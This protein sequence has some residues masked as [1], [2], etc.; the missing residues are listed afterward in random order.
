MAGRISYRQKYFENYDVICIA[1]GTNDYEIGTPIG[2]VVDTNVDTFYGA[3]MYIVERI[4]EQNPKAKV[5]FITPFYRGRLLNER[6]INCNFKKNKL[7]YTLRDYADAIKAV[8]DVHRYNVYD[9]N[10]AGVISLNNVS[11]STIDYIYPKEEYHGKIGCDM[12]DYFIKNKII[13]P[14]N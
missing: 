2:N 10:E 9:A 14:S 4:K 1:I 8:A 6:N 7:G 3:L 13:G 5:V 11:F 12:V